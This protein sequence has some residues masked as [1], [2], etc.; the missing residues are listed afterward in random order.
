MVSLELTLPIPVPTT[1]KEQ[2]WLA[3]GFTFGHGF[4][5]KLDQ[6]IQ[7]GTWFQGL[8]PWQQS[9]LKRLLDCL[10][11]WWMGALVW[12]YAPQ[13]SAPWATELAWFGAGLFVSDLSDVKNLYRRIREYFT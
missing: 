3:I 12:L 6:E 1:T 4:G 5:S 11:H 8:K 9:T 2:L 10:H 13:I 7:A